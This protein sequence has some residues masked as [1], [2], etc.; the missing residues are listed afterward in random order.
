MKDERSGKVLDRLRGQCARREYCRADVMKKALEALDGDRDA[1]L[2]V[3][4]KLVEGRYVDDFRYASA[5]ARDKSS[6]TGWGRARIRQMLSEKRIPD[7]IISEALK[8]VDPSRSRQRLERL[9][10]VKWKSI[11][12]T[13]QD[14]AKLFH[15]A[16]SRGYMYDEIK[17]VATVIFENDEL[18]ENEEL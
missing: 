9:M 18:N 15:Y 2:A 17:D 12:G 3:V 16:A 11:R 1:A 6:I 14:K 13:R 5:Y 7:G 8:E 10:A 4:E